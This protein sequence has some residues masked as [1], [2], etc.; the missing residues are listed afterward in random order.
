MIGMPVRQQYMGY[1]QLVFVKVFGQG[2]EPYRT[3]L[4]VK[5]NLN[6]LLINSL[7]GNF[8]NLTRVY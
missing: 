7:A 4:S 3:A 8:T 6:F 1:L 2:F 5:V